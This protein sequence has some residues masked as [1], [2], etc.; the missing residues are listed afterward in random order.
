[1]ATLHPPHKHMDGTFGS[2]MFSRDWHGKPCSYLGEGALIFVGGFFRKLQE[3][4]INCQNSNEL[5]F[6]TVFHRCPWIYYGVKG[7]A[8]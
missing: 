3:L 4:T 7:Y 5:Q 6:A 1:M 2:F 8:K